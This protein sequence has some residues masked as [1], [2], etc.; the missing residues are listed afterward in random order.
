MKKY[1]SNSDITFNVLIEGLRKHINF[2]PITSGGSEFTTDDEKVQKAL[3]SSHLFNTQFKLVEEEMV[4]E[5]KKGKEE[6]KL[7]DVEEI[8]NLPDAKSYLIEKGVKEETLKNKPSIVKAA[9][10]L[11]LN[12]PNLK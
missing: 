6:I 9:K 8:N 11:G 2:Y 12:F 7:T 10:V 5:V 4:S 3:E 1:R